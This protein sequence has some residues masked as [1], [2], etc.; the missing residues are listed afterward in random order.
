MRRF[1]YGKKL[2]NDELWDCFNEEKINQIPKYFYE[3]NPKN[4]NT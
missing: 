3:F 4:G 2:D 1:K